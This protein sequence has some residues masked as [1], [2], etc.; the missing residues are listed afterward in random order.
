MR[1]HGGH[2]GER[3]RPLLSKYKQPVIEPR[4]P[5]GPIGAYASA[6]HGASV[7]FRYK[8]GSNT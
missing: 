6:H 5:S 8:N 1:V 3:M 2:P 7:V 4:T